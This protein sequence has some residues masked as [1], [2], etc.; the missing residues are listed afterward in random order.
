[1]KL[2]SLRIAGFRGF[3]SERE[4]RFHPNLTLLGAPNSYGK[5]SIAEAL[6]FL[7]F[8]I[9]SRVEQADSKEEYKDSYRNRH[10]PTS[11]TI[12]VEARCLSSDGTRSVLRRTLQQD[13]TTRCF[14]NE[15]E[16]RDWPFG[17]HLRASATPFV[18][19]HALK[20]LLLV[21]PSER[22]LGFAR[23]LGL[24][25]VDSMHK[26]ITSLCTKPEVS[27]SVK[28]GKYLDSLNQLDNQ[29]ANVASL[30]AILLSLRK[31]SRAFDTT[32][33]LARARAAV[34]TGAP[35]L[36]LLPALAKKRDEIARGVYDGDPRVT[37]LQGTKIAQQAKTQTAIESVAAPAFVHEVVDLARL[38][39]LSRLQQQADFFKT[40]L[41]YLEEDPAQCP[42]CQ[43][44]NGD[45]AL[46][47]HIRDR[48]QAI[49]RDIT[50]PAEK[51]PRE[52]L[53]KQLSA[54]RAAIDANWAL[55]RSQIS[56]LMGV[57]EEDK[58]KRIRELLSSDESNA[59][60]S[61]VAAASAI[62]DCEH[63]VESSA[64]LARNAVELCEQT[65]NSRQ[66]QLSHAETAVTTTSA[67]LE[68]LRRWNST[69]TDW[70]DQVLAAAD[71]LQRAIDAKAGTEELSVLARLLERPDA[72][73]RSVKLKS[74]LD[75]LKTLRS[76]AQQSLGEVMEDAFNQ[77]LTKA[78]MRWYGMI[79]TSGDPDVHFDGFSMEKTKTGDYKSGRVRISAKSYG[80]ALASAVSSLSES[81]LNA[82][83]LCVSIASAIENGGPFNFLVLDDPIQ[84]WDAEHEV[85]FQS[86]VRELVAAEGRQVILVS[87]REKWISAVAEEC[88]ALRG[89]R[90]SISGYSQD[91]PE[92][93][94][95][96]WMPIDDRMRNI[97][98]VGRDTSS[99]ALDLQQAEADVRTA[100]C[101]ITASAAKRKLKRDRDPSK[102]N[103]KDTRA[104]LSD[105]KCPTGLADRVVATFVNTD[106]AHH[107]PTNYE[108]NRERI[109]QYHGALVDLRKW[110]GT[111]D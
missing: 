24:N 40:G 6:E 78:V 52:K 89:I 29:L 99:S 87:H 70:T 94:E 96:A 5:T 44:P 85:Q 13:G 32:V 55:L 51:D 97:L 16:V 43:S 4:I 72:I 37:R 69:V 81:K 47:R 42:L 19:Q 27:L 80:V 59:F 90:Y 63:V 95:S 71:T 86:L 83:G 2:D 67:H 91:G 61:L 106:D 84:S 38:D 28:A 31:G 35:D 9:T 14:L 93:V 54:A 1:M 77:K 33:Q 100:V 25:D 88:Q 111:L 65:I 101:E 92:L 18:I 102:L 82:L 20:E 98:R 62:R 48:H 75:D 105:M 58:Q 74:M 66:E 22:F 49:L 76:N 21:P 39:A 109:L 36:D 64:K 10:F 12:F 56:D 15:S 107:V 103:K 11:Q 30:K 41:Q 34:L 53:A 110:T 46:G 57:L 17:E 8:G 68:A 50:I 45:G 79:R 108:P 73:R 23:I 60:G 26:A 7:L 104:L 3:N